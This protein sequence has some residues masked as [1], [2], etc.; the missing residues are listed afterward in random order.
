M[1]VR[2]GAIGKYCLTSQIKISENGRNY[3]YFNVETHSVRWCYGFAKGTRLRIA[4]IF[5]ED[6]AS[7]RMSKC[8]LRRTCANL[9]VRVKFHGGFSDSFNPRGIWSGLFPAFSVM[10]PRWT[11]MRSVELSSRLGHVCA[12]SIPNVK[13]RLASNCSSGWFD[14]V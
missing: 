8:H 3:L 7:V 11:S 1:R 9:C 6:S 12:V 14:R 13:H 5:P 4:I 2:R 10:I